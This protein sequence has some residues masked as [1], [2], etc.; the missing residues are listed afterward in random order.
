MPP[1]ALAVS[2]G[3][4]NILQPNEYIAAIQNLKNGFSKERRQTAALVIPDYAVRMSVLDFVNFPAAEEEQKSLVRFRLKKSLPFS[5]DDAQISFSVQ[6]ADAAKK[7]TDVLAVAIAR[8][9][10]AQY[11]SLF[12]SNGFQVGLVIPSVIAALPLCF[13]EAPEGLTLF[14]KQSGKTLSLVLFE[15]QRILLVR[16][17]EIESMENQSSLESPV[18][19]VLHQTLAFAEDEIGSPVTNL[20]LCGFSGDLESVRREIQQEFRIAC[21]PVQSRFATASEETAGILGLLEQYAA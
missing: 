12:F 14:A 2:P 13:L 10:L 18:L 9:V 6:H 15:N 19:P 8:P 7:Q 17:T 3:V 16:C 4:E 1:G 11:E 20:L 21:R 5:V